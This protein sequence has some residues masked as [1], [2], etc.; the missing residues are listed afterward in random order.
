MPKVKI[1]IPIEFNRETNKEV[2]GTFSF[3]MKNIETYLQRV[4]CGKA[5]QSVEPFLKQ[6]LN[7]KRLK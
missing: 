1:Q 3:D 7:A 4:C 2:M 6:E 5:Y